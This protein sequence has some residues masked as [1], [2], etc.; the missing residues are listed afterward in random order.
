MR[1]RAV[2]HP[3]SWSEA[4]GWWR[5]REAKAESRY[6]AA[7]ECEENE[8]VACFDMIFVACILYFSS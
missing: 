6:K 3:D 1:T 8:T 4:N 2:A 5:W 7:R